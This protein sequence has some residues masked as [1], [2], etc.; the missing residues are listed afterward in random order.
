MSAGILALL[1]RR[2]D[3]S[4][5]LRVVGLITVVCM[6]IGGLA[7]AQVVRSSFNANAE[8]WLVS[9]IPMYSGQANGGKSAPAVFDN[10][11]GR[12]PGCLQAGDTFAET[13]L[14][15]PAKFVGNISSLYGAG[16]YYDI[17]VRYTDGTPY[18]AVLLCNTSMT[19]YYTAPSPQVGV[20]ETRGVPLVE[21]GWRVDK[22]QGRPATKSD[23]MAVLSTLTGLFI[24]TE[25]RSGPDNTNIDNVEIRHVSLAASGTNKIGTTQTFSLRASNDGG[26]TYQVGSALGI[27]PLHIRSRLMGLSLDGLLLIS[28]QGLAPSVFSGYAGSLDPFGNASA[29]MT[30]PAVSSLVGVWVHTAFLT[31]APSSPSGIK[32]ISNP[33]SLQIAP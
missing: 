21:N 19:L 11:A 7:A 14:R 5:S 6:N 8:N 20:W 18:P 33:W 27:G 15:A 17:Y 25:W 24:R 23:M 1:T 28:V 9:D 4:V 10:K 32:S 31:I 22:M 30:I 26:L 12:P 3:R 2:P 16:V 29:T 13:A